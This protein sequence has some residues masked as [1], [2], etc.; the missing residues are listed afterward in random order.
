MQIR[1]DGKYRSFGYYN[2]FEEAKEM[3]DKVY[4]DLFGEFYQG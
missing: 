3:A 4:K 2:E 1:V